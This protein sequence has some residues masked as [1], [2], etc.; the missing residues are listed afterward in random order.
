MKLPLQIVTAL[1]VGT[2]CGALIGSVAYTLMGVM[3]PDGVDLIFLRSTTLLMAILG[4]LFVGVPGGVVGLVVG[5]ARLGKFQ[6][7]VVGGGIGALLV[8][9]ATYNGFSDLRSAY[10]RYLEDGY[11]NTRIVFADLI[12]DATWL[13]GLTVTGVV[14]ALLNDS[15]LKS[16]QIVP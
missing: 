6:G 5:A 16:K 8:A 7:G 10:I 3:F 2:V 11:L 13:I 15:L 9:R 1:M 4:A 14:V 12:M